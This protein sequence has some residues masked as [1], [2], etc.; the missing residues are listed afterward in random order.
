MLKT[1]TTYSLLITASI[2]IGIFSAGMI[3][4]F[5]YLGIL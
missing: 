1:I 3:D 4:L 2:A 5:F